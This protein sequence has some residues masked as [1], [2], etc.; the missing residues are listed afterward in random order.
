M[1]NDIMVINSKHSLNP[2]VDIKPKLV[3][4]KL[5]NL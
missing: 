3:L 1:N 5:N 4:L 2:D